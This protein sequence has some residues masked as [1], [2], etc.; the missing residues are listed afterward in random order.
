MAK[1][2]IND[3]LMPD[4]SADKKKIKDEKKK[5]KDEQK[6]Q[7]KDNRKRAKELAKKEAE[8]DDDSEGGAVS[9]IFVTAA[10][11]VAWL[12]ILGLLIR[13]DV[14][15]IG[16]GVL[17]PILKDVP[18]VKNILPKSSETETSN[19]EEYGGYTSLK[20][21]VE[22]IQSLEASL[23]TTNNS[24][25]SKTDRITELE[26]EVERLKTFEKNQVE[27]QRIKTEFYEEVVYSDKGPGVEEYLKY[28][29]TMDPTT[30]E[31]LYQEAVAKQEESK[32][33]IKYAQA[34]SEMKPKEA[35]G[36]FEAMTDN[37]DLAA[38]ILHVMEPDD[39]GKILGAMDPTIAAKI[40]KIMDPKS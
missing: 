27:F 37:L 5:L 18:V 6:L 29:E 16:S 4:T 19:V 2:N 12:V 10:I 35:A 9:T 23:E 31:Y 22:K 17:A 36:I 3:S 28:F 32:E 21:A 14:G 15:G 39:R 8:L 38:R 33:V 7:K 1:N 34:Y 26:A 13:M 24:D 30:A 20:E 25:Q 40:T 11:V